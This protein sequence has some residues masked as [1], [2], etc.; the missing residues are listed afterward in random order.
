M[1]GV[2]TLF[3]A[4]IAS[5]AAP[6]PP[7]DGASF[8]GVTEYVRV[9]FN[10]NVGLAALT[11]SIWVNL[12]QPHGTQ[13]FLNRGERGELFTLYLYRNHIRMLV[14]HAPG[15]YKYATTEPPQAETW[16]H[17]VGVYDGE[18]ITLYV[19]GEPVDSVGAPGRIPNRDAP[20]F[21]GAASP[22]MNTVNGRLEDVRVYP[23]AL[24]PAQIRELA[25]GSARASETILHLS[26]ADLV[27]RMRSDS[28]VPENGEPEL[29]IAMGK[30]AT[31]DGF[32][33]IWYANQ[34][35]D[36]GLHKYSGGLGTYPQQHHPIA[37]YAEAVNK[38][39]FTYG[40]T[41][42]DRNQLLHMVSAYDHE[43]GRVARPRILLDK[44]TD[45]AHDNPT[46]AIDSAGYIWI[47]S[48]AHGTSRPAYIH[49]STEPYSIDAFTR[50]LTTN[51]SYSQP[52]FLPEFGFVFLHTRYSQGRGLFVDTSE[53]GVNWDG[54]RSLAHIAAGHYQVSWPNG[55]R[56][57]TAFNYHPGSDSPLGHGLNYRTNLYYAETSDGGKTWQT[58][59]GEMLEI[60]LTDSDNPA[61]VAEYESRKRLV[62]LK[63]IQYTPEGHPVILYLTSDGWE[64]GPENDPRIFTT[65]RWTGSEWEIHP[66]TS[67]DNNYD[68]ASL[69]I[70]EDGTWRV[71]G[72]TETG[73][74]PF[75]TGGEMALWVS[76][77]QG[78]SWDLAQHLTSNSEYNHTY[79]RRPLNAHSGFY[80]LWADGH[81]RQP[82]PSRFYFTNRQ[83]HVYRLPDQIE[84]GTDWIL[85]ERVQ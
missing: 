71:I 4:T 81:A 23:M 2:L 34:R 83:G 39:F 42:K 13:V 9:D 41:R 22:M 80:A 26:A 19:D 54:P 3:M 11:V 38:T 77:D 25:A 76:R 60:P 32:R 57:G 31:T 49:R 84:E 78:Q 50:Q 63:D 69:Y 73:P 48:N 45:D 85:P 44:K 53:D 21:I 46:M 51:F 35:S 20:F 12:N 66:V 15:Q 16:T 52:W 82:S 72:S 74:Q 70:E 65:A 56:I 64:S 43:T 58:V 6:L 75:N 79:P 17:Y 24:S 62:Y 5:P 68:F 18:T 47:Y 67:A 37:V 14:E 7:G 30:L 40:G 29:P 59:G 28:P 61:R 55:S 8:D 1:T 10:K 36:D 27:E 33:G